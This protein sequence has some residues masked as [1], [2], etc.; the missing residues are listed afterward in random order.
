MAETRERDEATL[1]TIRQ[2]IQDA[3]VDLLGTPADVVAL[4]PPNAV[5]KTSSGKIRRSSAREVY[6][7]GRM[8]RRGAALG[9]QIANLA[10]SGLRAQIARRARSLGALLYTAWAYGSFVLYAVPCWIAI[11]AAPGLKARRTLARG[12]ARFLFAW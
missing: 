9:L 3:T 2:A 10:L 8:G 1:E 4:V 6:E 7:S 5:P 12:V 11:V